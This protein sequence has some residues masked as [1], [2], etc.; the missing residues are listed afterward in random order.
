MFSQEETCVEKS[1]IFNVRSH[2]LFKNSGRHK[3]SMTYSIGNTTLN[4]YPPTLE[5]AISFLYDAG[6]ENLQQF[7]EISWPDIVSVRT[8]AMFKTQK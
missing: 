5:H 3:D 1:F 8:F 7:P 4:L 6:K 2:L